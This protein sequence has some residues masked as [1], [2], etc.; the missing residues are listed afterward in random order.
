MIELKDQ[1]LAE[2][3]FKINESKR[4]CKSSLDIFILIENL[5]LVR[6]TR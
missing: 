2:L 5:E 3:R 1:K 4:I 6:D